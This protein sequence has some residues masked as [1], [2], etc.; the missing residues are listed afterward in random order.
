MNAD[1][2]QDS[3]DNS[4]Y[5][6]EDWFKMPFPPASPMRR[7]SWMTRD[8]DSIWVSSIGHK[9]SITSGTNNTIRKESI[10]KTPSTRSDIP[11]MNLES[12]MYWKSSQLPN[13]NELDKTLRPFGSRIK[14]QSNNFLIK[15]F[16]A[17]LI[18]SKSKR[19]RC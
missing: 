6:D 9:E 4:W 1:N 7:A 3:I 12:W 17:W 8:S 13:N 10:I 11:D 14:T 18:Y 5:V 15:L 16:R 2:E 19:S